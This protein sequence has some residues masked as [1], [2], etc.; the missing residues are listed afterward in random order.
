[1]GGEDDMFV[2]IIIVDYLPLVRLFPFLLVA[3]PFLFGTTSFGISLPLTFIVPRL[4]RAAV[5]GQVTETIAGAALV[6]AKEPT[7]IRLV[8][9]RTALAAAILN[10]TPK[11]RLWSVGLVDSFLFLEFPGTLQS[12]HVFL[13]EYSDEFLG[14]GMYLR[15]A[16]VALLDTYIQPREVIPGRW[17]G[18]DDRDLE[19]DFGDLEITVVDQ[20][21]ALPVLF[22]G[23]KVLVDVVPLFSSSMPEVS[24]NSNSGLLAFVLVD[25]FEVMPGSMGGDTMLDVDKRFVSDV[26]SN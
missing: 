20:V 4:L 16:I 1:M 7:V 17:Q 18:R 10:V 21:K 14:H 25:C 5:F 6:L 11:G 3:E 24:D 26:L 12:S 9:L 15:V 8:V 13:L 22:E 19:L 2:I 23:R